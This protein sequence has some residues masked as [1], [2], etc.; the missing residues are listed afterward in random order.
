MGSIAIFI[1]G[2]Y[3]EKV[4]MEEFEHILT[5]FKLLAQ[6]ISTIVSPESELL[7]TYY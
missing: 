6:E 1:D 2:G 5:D 7:R 4:R 3:F